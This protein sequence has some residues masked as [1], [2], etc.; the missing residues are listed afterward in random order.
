MTGDVQVNFGA[1]QMRAYP[2]VVIDGLDWARVA[3]AAEE[4]GDL[5]DQVTVE[6]PEILDRIKRIDQPAE[7]IAVAA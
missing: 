3:I 2:F 4:L 7:Q 1:T 5:A 6:L